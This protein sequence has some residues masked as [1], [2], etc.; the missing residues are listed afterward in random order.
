MLRLRATFAFGRYGFASQCAN[1]ANSIR[2]NPTVKLSITIDRI[3]V[4]YENTFT[5]IELPIYII[6]K[7]FYASFFFYW[8]YFESAH[9]LFINKRENRWWNAQNAR[10]ILGVKRY[11][12]YGRDETLVKVSLMKTSH[13]YDTM[14]K[15]CVKWL[16]KTRE[17]FLAAS[18][19]CE[20]AYSTANWRENFCSFLRHTLF[21]I[22]LKSGT[23]ASG[24]EVRG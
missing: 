15:S 19:T 7:K 20:E 9:I 3:I 6:F 18:R 16:R 17:K 5:L 11:G 1:K 10:G 14:K 12:L 22:Y 4:K 24:N 2:G 13:I 21:I 23:W 8:K